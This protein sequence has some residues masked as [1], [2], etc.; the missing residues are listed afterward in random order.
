M[1]DINYRADAA[2]DE[3]ETLDF[4]PKIRSACSDD[5]LDIFVLTHP[6]EDHLCGFGDIFHLGK[7]EDRDDDPDEGDVLILVDEIWCSEYSADPNYTTSKSKPLLDEISRRKTLQGTSA[8]RKDGNRLKVLTASSGGLST[9]CNGIE[10]RLLAPNKTEA[11][12]PKAKDGEAENSSNSSSLVIQW[13]VTVRGRRSV[14]V[15]AGDSTVDVWERLNDEMTGEQ[16]EW[17]VLLAPHH[18]SRRSLGRKEEKNGKDVFVWSDGAYDGL[19]HPIG[20]KSHVVASSRKF[21]SNHPPH[22][23]ARD[24]YRKILAQ[25]GEVTQSVRD[26]FKCTAGA[27]GEKTK[28]VVVPM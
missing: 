4:A 6:D 3:S 9:L 27:H 15:L 7:P 10:W 21:G 8:G 19:D 28:D 26:R 17:D 2:D 18:C 24:K 11:D 1:T 5:R 23:E 16:L 14:F 20:S 25:G 12:I 13:T 22:P